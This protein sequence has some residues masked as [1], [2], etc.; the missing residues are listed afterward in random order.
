LISPDDVDW[1]GKLLGVKKSEVVGLITELR[2]N[3]ELRFL[4]FGRH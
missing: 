3:V 2:E 1:E 4:F